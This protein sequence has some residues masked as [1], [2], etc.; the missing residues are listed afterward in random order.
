MTLR[1][2]TFLAALLAAAPVSATDASSLVGDDAVAAWQAD[3]TRVFEATEVDLKE[4]QWIAR[5]IVVFADTPADPRFR[6]QM[7]LLSERVGELADR[8]VIVITD[9]D[10]KERSAIRRALRPRGFMIAL[11]G[12]D[13]T[14]A[15]RKP[16]P[17]SVRELSRSIDKMPLRQEEIRA[18]KIGE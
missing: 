4:F 10:P 17:W 5:P 2:L 16:F 9:S 12:K 8:D 3:P 1:T 15:L 6:E 13:G 18:R 14:V 7:E 11:L